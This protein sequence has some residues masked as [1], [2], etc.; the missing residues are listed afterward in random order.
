MI[1]Q[2]IKF[3]LVVRVRRIKAIKQQT[4]R[5]SLKGA[6]TERIRSFKVVVICTS[7]HRNWIC[8]AFWGEKQDVL[9]FYTSDFCAASKG[10]AAPSH[11]DTPTQAMGHCPSPPWGH[12]TTHLSLLNGREVARMC[13]SLPGTAGSPGTIP[14]TSENPLLPGYQKG[15]VLFL[16]DSGCIK[17]ERNP[18]KRL[19]MKCSA[20][21]PQEF[22]PI[23][24]PHLAAW[25]PPG[26]SGTWARQCLPH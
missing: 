8:G 16:L 1:F 18:H 9:S 4:Q 19:H 23:L 12:N 3:A 13:P 10:P 6:F 20:K 26:E 24:S 11:R 5:V 15:E 14:K 22:T 25:I 2:W 21:G 17:A 7:V